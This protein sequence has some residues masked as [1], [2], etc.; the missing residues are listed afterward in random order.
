MGQLPMLRCCP[1]APHVLQKHHI[2]STTEVDAMASASAPTSTSTNTRSQQSSTFPSASD[3]L[4]AETWPLSIV[5]MMPPASRSRRV[6]S[7]PSGERRGYR[8][9][10]D[11]ARSGRS[12]CRVT[13]VVIP[14]GHLRFAHKKGRHAR[15]V[16]G[17]CSHLCPA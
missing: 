15:S 16:F 12:R 9:Y 14:R 11:Y 2:Y 13:Q 8:L 7:R 5:S 3:I 1:V 17:Q 6:G 4:Q 10:C